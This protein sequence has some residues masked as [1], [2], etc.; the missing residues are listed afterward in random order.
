MLTRE[1]IVKDPLGFHLRTA[2]GVV[3]ITRAHESQ[4]EFS[5]TDCDNCPR[6][7]ACSILELITLGAS[8][9][10]TLLIAV[11]GPDEE[12]VMREM[13]DLFDGGGGI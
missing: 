4:V 5:C 11:D 9:G 1:V 7:N 13:K 3:E 10:S 8:Q 6:V 2:A 12:V